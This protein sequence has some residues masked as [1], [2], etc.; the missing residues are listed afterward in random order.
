VEHIKQT[1]YVKNIGPKLK[2]TRLI[3]S[4]RVVDKIEH[5]F[6]KEMYTALKKDLDRFDFNS[7]NPP[8][9]LQKI[10]SFLTGNWARSV[11]NTPSVFLKQV[12]SFLPYAEG[13]DMSKYIAN[14]LK[15]LS[16]PM[17][18][19]KFMNDISPYIRSR[20]NAKEYNEFFDLLKNNDNPSMS[21][22]VIDMVQT[23]QK[24]FTLQRFTEKTLVD[25]GDIMSIIFGG[26]ARYQT[27]IENGMTAEDA[28]KDFELQTATTQQSNFKSLKAN[29]IKND[30]EIYMRLATMFKSQ[31]FQYF[32]KNLENI[33]DWQHGDKTKDK[34]IKG[35][36]LY[37]TLVPLLLTGVQGV[38]NDMVGKKDEDMWYYLKFFLKEMLLNIFGIGLMGHSISLALSNYNTLENAFWAAWGAITGT[39]L[40]WIKRAT[41]GR[42][43]R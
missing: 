20:F 37:N 31:S 29:F 26:Y 15:G 36:I 18:T 17:E 28:L 12:T 10:I 32:N 38:I 40:S 13:L 35:F 2:D 25:M 21:D 23:I 39:P 30:S 27:N 9:D 24:K 11:T 34:A 5:L 3:F 8:T 6:G 41:I 7:Y 19:K 14:Y 4:G 43:K 16:N 33:I 1:E 22:T 42:A